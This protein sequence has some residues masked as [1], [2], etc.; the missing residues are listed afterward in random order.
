[1]CFF[2]DNHGHGW[3]PEQTISF[4]IDPGSEEE[5]IGLVILALSEGQPPQTINGDWLAAWIGE[6]PWGM[7]V[8][9]SDVAFV[10]ADCD[11]D[12]LD[13]LWNGRCSP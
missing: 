4:I 8:V 13:T 3:S 7:G 11:A 5:R 10:A 2:P 1:M 6:P 9:D 12:L